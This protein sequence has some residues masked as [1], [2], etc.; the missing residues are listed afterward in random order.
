MTYRFTQ[1]QV[2]QVETALVLSLGYFPST[3]DGNAALE[4]VRQALTTLRDVVNPSDSSTQRPTKVFDKLKLVGYDYWGEFYEV[5]E[6]V[7]AIIKYG[8]PVYQPVDGVIPYADVVS[9]WHYWQAE[10][11]KLRLDLENLRTTN[12]P[13]N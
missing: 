9:H 11:E 10:A 7:P 4:K 6:C 3:V 2:T 13:D 1:K 8:T 12:E 5:E